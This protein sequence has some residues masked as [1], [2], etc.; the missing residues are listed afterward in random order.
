MC[1]DSSEV[2]SDVGHV[3]NELRR[4]FPQA[5]NARAFPEAAHDAL[6]FKELLSL[7]ELRIRNVVRYF[8]VPPVLQRPD[9]DLATV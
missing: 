5:E 8:M 4:R 1:P 6:Q 3:E 9:A 7:E 2:A